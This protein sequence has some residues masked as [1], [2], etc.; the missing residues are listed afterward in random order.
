MAKSKGGHVPVG[1]GTASANPQLRAVRNRI[2]AH[3]AWAPLG[4][5]QGAGKIGAAAWSDGGGPFACAENGGGEAL[6][7]RARLRPTTFPSGSPE[8]FQPLDNYLIP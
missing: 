5:F 7:G 8:L 6:A 3:L 2:C 1:L 4:G